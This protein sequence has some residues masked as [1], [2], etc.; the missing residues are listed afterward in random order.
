[1]TTRERVPRVVL[2]R[3]ADGEEI[4]RRTYVRTEKAAARNPGAVVAAGSGATGVPS[5]KG[6]GSSFVVPSRAT[7]YIARFSPLGKSRPE[8]NP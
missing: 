5:G 8:L 2:V 6:K 1:M 3:R 4:H 7:E